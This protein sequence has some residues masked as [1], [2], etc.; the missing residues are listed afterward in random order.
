MRRAASHLAP[1]AA[2]SKS[3]ILEVV[4]GLVQPR[5]AVPALHLRVVGVRPVQ[6]RLAVRE[7]ERGELPRP[8]FA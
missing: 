5:L 6:S 2:Q 4:H 8:E 3:S 7:A 1:S